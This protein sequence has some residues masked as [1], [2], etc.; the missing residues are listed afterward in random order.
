M[1]QCA[2]QKKI[3]VG[4]YA[5][6]DAHLKELIERG[7]TGARIGLKKDFDALER[8]RLAEKAGIDMSGSALYV[9][10]KGY[11]NNT[12]AVRNPLTGFRDWGNKFDSFHACFFQNVPKFQPVG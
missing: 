4:K 9:E 1:E 2:W 10:E 12:V 5:Q 8:S 7:H 6:H 3:A 11:P